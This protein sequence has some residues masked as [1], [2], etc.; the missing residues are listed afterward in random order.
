MAFASSS[1]Y[2]ATTDAPALVVFL[3]FDSCLVWEAVAIDNTVMAA[4]IVPTI[5]YRAVLPFELA[6]LLQST[7]GREARLVQHRKTRYGTT[8][9]QTK[10]V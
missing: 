7:S 2:S 5:I 10:I 1:T 4:N 6:N 9:E 8:M 3:L